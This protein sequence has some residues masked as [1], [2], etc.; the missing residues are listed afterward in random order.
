MAY[1]KRTGVAHCVDIRRWPSSR[2]LPWFNGPS[3]ESGLIAAGLRY[4]WL[5]ESLGGHRSQIVPVEKSP[6][7]AWREEAFR[8]YAD[9]MDSQEFLD[10]VTALEQVASRDSTA[11]LCA[12]RAWHN[13]HR[14]L[15]SD[16]LTV[17]GWQVAHI[18]DDQVSEPHALH[19]YGRV[20]GRTITYPSLL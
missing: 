12:E 1:W 10:G 18:Q 13:C 14:R 19:E 17:R 15:L 11:Y 6:N 9:A 5:G 8:N 20:N 4:T 7:R 16:L 2:R 3:L